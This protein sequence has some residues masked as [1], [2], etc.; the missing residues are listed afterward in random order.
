LEP[1]LL[2]SLRPTFVPAA[3][4]AITA[5]AVAYGPALPPS[6]AGLT[7]F[8]PYAVLLIGVAISVWFNRGRGFIALASLLAAYAA[9][10]L[11]L[12]YGAGPF[13]MRAVFTGLALFVPLNIFLALVLPERGVSH[14]TNYR[15]LLLAAAEILLV[16]WVAAA[17][18][19][20]FSGTAWHGVL[21]HWLLSV[22]PTPLLGRILFALAFAAAAARAWIEADAL[23]LRPMDVGLGGALL[24]F[25]VACEWAGAP[26]AFGAFMSA[27]GVILLVS[28]LQESHRMAFH[29]QLT[30]LPGRRA[31]EERMPGL[32]PVYAMAMVDVDHFKQ[33]N[34]THGHD[35]GDQ[36]LKLV[37]A[38]LAEI[39]GGGTAYR[40]G[41]EEF[42]VLFPNKQLADAL[43]HLEEMRQTIEGYRMA[44]R[45]P[46]RPKDPETGT[47][48]RSGPAERR[49][50][51]LSVTVSIGAAERDDVL[52]T[53]PMVLRA[54]D[55][56][57]YRAKQ[58]GRNRVSR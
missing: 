16:A 54:A 4:L 7:V 33:F 29:D 44:V 52:T 48:L 3:I 10:S 58:G 56:A 18:R 5:L 14:H 32:G 13:A 36:V 19:S 46:N 20:S 38:R 12:D 11:T 50:N 9:F 26:G 1:G 40:Y 39:G 30:G 34:D 43:P 41:G 28:L 47:Q 55:K 8:G 42:A 22:P 49:D 57:L 37:A 31:L 6:L 17:G 23:E 45:G 24:A 25:L 53:P 15:W 21:E 27:A 51:M 2:R 35:V